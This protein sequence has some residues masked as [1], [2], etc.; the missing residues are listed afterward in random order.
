MRKGT[1]AGGKI[2]L[3]DLPDQALVAHPVLDE[4]LDRDQLQRV[5]AAE[6]LQARSARHRSV[7]VHHLADH[8]RRVEAGQAGQVHRGLGLARAH[9]H[10][11]VHGP[12]REHVAGTGQVAGPGRG[13]DGREHGARAIARGD[14]GGRPLLGLDGHAEG[15]PELRV[16]LLVAHHERDAQLVQPLPGHGQADEAAAVAGHEVDDFGGDLL[17]GDGEV[18]LVL[19]VLVVHDHDHP[20]L[21][22]VFDGVGDA[23]ERHR[24]SYRGGR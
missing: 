9:E 10:A 19:A 15:G 22:D 2:G 12:Q 8:A 1:V 21:P 17:R 23:G 7:F 14:P 6:G 16:V 20:A 3:H 18:A 4:V 5:L 11:A 13:I 24:T